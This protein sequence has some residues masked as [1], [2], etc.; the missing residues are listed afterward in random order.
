M[1]KDLKHVIYYRFNTVSDILLYATPI[2]PAPLGT[3]WQGT[4]SGNMGTRL[5]G[6]DVLPEGCG[7]V[8]RAMAG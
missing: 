3:C 8:I 4:W 2:C 1:C 5:E 7:P 6:L